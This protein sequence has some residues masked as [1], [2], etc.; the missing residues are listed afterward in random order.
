MDKKIEAFG[1]ARS[2]WVLVS[3]DKIYLT[4]YKTRKARGS[5]KIPTPENIV[6]LSVHL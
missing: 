6:M 1:A 4:V 3:V 2:G 5:S